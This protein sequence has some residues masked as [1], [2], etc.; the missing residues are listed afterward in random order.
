MN[1]ETFEKIHRGLT[2]TATVSFGTAVVFA[3]DGYNLRIANDITPFGLETMP[4]IIAG[5]FTVGVLSVGAKLVSYLN[6]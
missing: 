3:I 5:L 1:Q 4:W 2:T 6:R